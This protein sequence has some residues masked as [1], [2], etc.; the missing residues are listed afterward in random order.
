MIVWEVYDDDGSAST[1]KVSDAHQ[2]INIDRE[3]L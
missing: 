2:G 3:E 1:K